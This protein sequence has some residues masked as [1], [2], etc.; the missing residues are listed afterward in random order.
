MFSESRRRVR[1]A[2]EQWA[3]AE[4]G[5]SLS[6]ETFPTANGLRSTDT[7]K[8]EK[9]TDGATKTANYTLTRVGDV[10]EVRMVSWARTR[11]QALP[12]ADDI[13]KVLSG[14]IL[15]VSANNVSGIVGAQTYTPC[16]YWAFDGICTKI[17]LVLLFRLLWSLVP[18]F[19]CIMF[20]R[21]KRSRPQGN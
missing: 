7:K 10:I 14:P 4:T 13:T 17:V 12:L 20:P 18:I 15:P 5:R 19:D 9:E 16:M 21:T 6:R 11:A 1:D 8:P 2:V 3:R